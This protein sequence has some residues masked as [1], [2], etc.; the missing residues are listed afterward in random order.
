MSDFNT[1]PNRYFCSVLA[2]MRTCHEVGNYSGLL[3][4]IEELQTLGNRMEASLYDKKDMHKAH[5]EV[6]KLK[7]EI[8]KL[9]KK[10]KKLKE[11]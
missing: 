4:L 3:G 6:R 8:K 7:K 1:S 11:K 9:E 5:G 10:K 2:E